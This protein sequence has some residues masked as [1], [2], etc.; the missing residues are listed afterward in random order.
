M[1]ESELARV[2]DRLPLAPRPTWPGWASAPLP[3][4]V[5][6]VQKLCL[7][8]EG[9]SRPDFELD[10]LPGPWPVTIPAEPERHSFA[11]LA[12]VFAER[13]EL[14]QT[15]RALV[16]AMLLDCLECIRPTQRRSG[17]PSRLDPSEA[18]RGLFTDADLDEFVAS[19][20][21]YLEKARDGLGPLGS[22]LCKGSQKPS[23]TEAY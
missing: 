9:A 8:E 7:V 22:G 2:V 3:V 10:S 23:Q 4:A 12:S 6:E 19:H 21:Q 18:S 15:V 16:S 1:D 13:S 11:A 14:D 20:R 5:S 17:A